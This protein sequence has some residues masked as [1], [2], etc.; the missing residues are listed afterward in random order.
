MSELAEIIKEK[1]RDG[2]DAFLCLR[3]CEG[4]VIPALIS[5]GDEIELDGVQVGSL[6]YPLEKILARLQERYP[7]K[8]FAVL[9]RGCDERAMIELAK[10]EQL[11]LDRVVMVGVA[12]S[13]GEAEACGCDRPYPGEI[14]LG[15][16]A[17]PAPSR[18]I[19]DEVESLTPSERLEWWKEQFSRCIKC[20]G[21]RN[22]CPMCFCKECALEDPKL[23][24]P[25]VIP[26]ESPSFHVIRALDM[27]GRCIDCGLCEEAC[28][29]EIPLR[30]LY[31][32]MREIMEES[33]GYRAGESVEEKNPLSF[34]GSEEDIEKLEQED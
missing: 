25:G 18:G 13:A 5:A 26:P 3:D 11:D 15:E 20:Y 1:L 32:K 24:E 14:V 22:I 27:A 12:C 30:S 28:P 29:A 33:L 34:L 9:A 23:V 8:R 19:I 16:R 17:E 31:R 21:C 10:L 4:T 6:R 7:D 2:A